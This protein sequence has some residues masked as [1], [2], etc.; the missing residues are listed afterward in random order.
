MRHWLDSDFCTFFC[1]HVVASTSK[2]HCKGGRKL[3]VEH[4]TTYTENEVPLVVPCTPHDNQQVEFLFEFELKLVYN[5]ATFLVLMFI[6]AK[7]GREL[8]CR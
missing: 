8:G 1:Y 7:H 3:L 4:Q 6:F 2:K 5:L